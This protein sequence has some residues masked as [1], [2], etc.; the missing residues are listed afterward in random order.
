MNLRNPAGRYAYAGSHAITIASR[1][2][3]FEVKEMTSVPAAIVQQ[4]RRIAIIRNHYVRKTVIIEV[5]KS[6]SSSDMRVLKAITRN[7][8]GLSELAVF[9][10]KE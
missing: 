2:Y 9:I 7:L 5:Q 10:M 1:S 4:Q 3:E 8:G 6:N